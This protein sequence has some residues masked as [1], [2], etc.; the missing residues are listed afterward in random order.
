[1]R[2]PAAGHSVELGA[3]KT[4]T[5]FARCSRARFSRSSQ[6]ACLNKDS[7]SKSYLKKPVTPFFPTYISIH[8][9]P[10]LYYERYRYQY[11]TGFTPIAPPGRFSKP[12]SCSQNGLPQK[13]LG[14]AG[15]VHEMRAL[16]N[17]GNARAWPR[18]QKGVRNVL[19]VCRAVRRDDMLSNIFKWILLRVEGTAP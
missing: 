13:R 14:R 3:T 12:P 10:I 16:A 1:L 5:G 18:R 2:S 19:K 8:I 15:S 6:V 7:Y 9:R 11:V 4:L 17:L